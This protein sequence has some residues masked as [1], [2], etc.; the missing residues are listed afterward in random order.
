MKRIIGGF[1]IF[2]LVCNILWLPTPAFAQ[3]ASIKIGDYV[4]M[5]QY[6]DEP[7]L[8]RCVD[9]DEN[10]PLMLSDKILCLK[11]FDAAGDHPND[12]NSSRLGRGSNL[13]ETSNIRSWLNAASDSNVTW[14]CGN[15]PTDDRIWGG[16][17]NYENEKGFICNENFTQAERSLLKNVMQKSLLDYYDRAMADGGTAAHDYGETLATILQNYD[18]AY[19]KYITD[20]MFLLDVKQLDSVCQNGDILGAD[21][22]KSMPTLKAAEHS[23][24]SINNSENWYYYLRTPDAIDHDGSGTNVGVRMVS[25]DGS[26]DHDPS[27]FNGSIGIRP[28][29]YLDETY[30][31]F[32]FGNGTK[33]TPY[34]LAGGSGSTPIEPILPTGSGTQT[35]PYIIASANNLL[36]VTDNNANN[37]GFLD[38][39][40]MQSADIVWEGQW[41]P[42][43][44][45]DYKFAGNYSGNGHSI[46]GITITNSS[47]ENQ[48][49]FGFNK[50]T[51]KNLSVAADINGIGMNVGGL[52]GTNNGTI[53]N[54]YSMSN[55]VGK[56]EIGGLIGLVEDNGIVTNCYATGN[57]RG[58]ENVSCDVG[59]LIGD[60]HGTIANCFASCSISSD[61]GGYY[62]SMGGFCADCGVGSISNCYASSTLSGVSNNK[63]LVIGITF[64]GTVTNCSTMDDNLF[65]N[66]AT[67]TTSS[68][69]DLTY[70][71][72]F[73]NTWAI[74]LTGTMNNGYP[75]LIASSSSD[76]ATPY[77]ISGLSANTLNNNVEIT[78]SLKNNTTSSNFINVI[79]CVYNSSNQLIGLN[80]ENMM[81]SAEQSQLL[82]SNIIVPNIE[83]EYIVKIFVIENLNNIKPLANC[84]AYYSQ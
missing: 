49:L 50:G 68:N 13:W 41:Q 80:K 47:V 74:D 58:T 83:N 71:W 24:F 39:Y 72:D 65:K 56:N 22:Y 33:N 64:Y 67:F 12:Y 66:K 30:A 2:V 27:A 54:C 25:P 62:S 70:P 34:M 76:I 46:K 84:E 6:Y 52:V 20:K 69:W 18:D 1:I 78:A 11:P 15:P 75:Y 16:Y 37:N 45:S 9:I 7:I 26:V 19:F 38:K 28:A 31:Y 5:G 73:S 4:Q 10:G 3:A 57:I 79:Y 44:D 8:W 48:G 36:W 61:Q 14:L 40:F 42:I 59:G 53:I 63:G 60:S 82:Q 51:I 77:T 23:E 35:D 21:Y 29:F 32:A 43:G 55:I 17:N 81:L